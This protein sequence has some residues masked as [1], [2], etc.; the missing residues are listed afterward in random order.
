MRAFVWRVVERVTDN[1]HDGGGVLAVAYDLESARALI[2]A[3][4]P[5]C[6]AG[7]DAPDIEFVVSDETPPMV[8]LFPNAGCC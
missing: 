6:S 8:E 1:Y 3:Q 5:S 7:L 4:A 2:D